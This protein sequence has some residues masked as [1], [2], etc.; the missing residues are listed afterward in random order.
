MRPHAIGRCSL[1]LLPLLS[2]CAARATAPVTPQAY[3]L[4]AAAARTFTA[5]IQILTDWTLPI[6]NTDQA[7]GVISSGDLLIGSGGS[8]QGSAVG[9]WANCGS[10]MFVSRAATADETHMRFTVVLV[11]VTPDSTSMRVQVA[12]EVLERNALGSPRAPCSSRG[13]LE[14]LFVEAVRRRLAT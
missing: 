10:E 5:A 8:F 11:P 13:L 14:P 2:A 6:Q 3:V 9:H 7:A 12:I 4:P 1:L